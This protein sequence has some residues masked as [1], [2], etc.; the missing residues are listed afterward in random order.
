MQDFIQRF[1]HKLGLSEKQASII[2]S[3]A[4]MCEDLRLISDNTPP[5]MA[6]GCIYLYAR[7]QGVE[8]T[9]KDISDVCKLRTCV[10]PP[11][12]FI[13]Y[14]NHHTCDFAQVKLKR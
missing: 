10:A 4:E 6:T 14:I 8:I 9:K 2:S 1:C 12:K 3:I 7:K 5:S 11:A 13:L